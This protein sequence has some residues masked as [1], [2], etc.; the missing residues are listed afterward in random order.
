MA[1]PHF[2]TVRA[3][4]RGGPVAERDGSSFGAALNLAARVAVPGID[5]G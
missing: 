4:V 3:G 1:E 2:S 5:G